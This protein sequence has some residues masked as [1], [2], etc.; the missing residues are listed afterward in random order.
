MH[1]KS[2]CSDEQAGQSQAKAEGEVSAIARK[3]RYGTEDDSNLQK[4]FPKI[5]VAGLAL[6]M[7]H[8]SLKFVSFI[9]LFR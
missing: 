5:V 7:D 9:L 1:H 2:A 4:C 3:E 8:F 6:G